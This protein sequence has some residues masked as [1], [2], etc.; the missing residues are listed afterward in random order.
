M[1][2]KEI[3]EAASCIRTLLKSEDTNV[4]LKRVCE[5]IKG[6][7]LQNLIVLKDKVKEVIGND[8]RSK[9]NSV[10]GTSERRASIETFVIAN[11]DLI[12]DDE[13]VKSALLDA[14]CK[15]RIKKDRRQE[16]Q[17]SLIDRCE[18]EFTDDD[19]DDQDDLDF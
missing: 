12:R 8:M 6:E 16:M 1:S 5:L 11:W 15:G 19:T 13:H 18:V 3:R 4:T 2:D 17:Q 14:Y 7:D 9:T 10:T